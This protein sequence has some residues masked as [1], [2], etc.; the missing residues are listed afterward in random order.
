[1]PNDP[2]RWRPGGRA[3]PRARGPAA[4]SLALLA[5]AVGPGGPVGCFAP[6]KTVVAR[7]ALEQELATSAARRT[8]A[9]LD[10]GALD[11]GHPY[12]LEIAAPATSDADVVRSL[13]ET[14]LGEAGIRLI[15]RADADVPV[16]RATVPFASVDAEASLLG[17]P[18]VVPGLPVA[19]GD[20]SL[21]KSSTLTGRA[22]IELSVW[23]PE[24]DLEAALPAV[25]GSRYYRNVTVLTFVGPF[26]FTDLARPLPGEEP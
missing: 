17:I 4:W 13:L 3:R 12:R 19:L 25:E 6:L 9:R 15:R 22:R 24:G 10:L 21:Y 23:S 8:A 11:R 5:L 14:R 7:S 2:T 1:M 16:L 20:I 26:R 18:F